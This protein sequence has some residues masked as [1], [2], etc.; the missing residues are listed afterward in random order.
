MLVRDLSRLAGNSSSYR[1]ES[2]ILTILLVYFLSV[3]Y[4]EISKGLVDRN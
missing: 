2:R 3:L 4:E 1:L